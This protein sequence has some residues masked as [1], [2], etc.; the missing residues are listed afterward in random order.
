MDILVIMCIGV[1]IGN[2]WFPL[3]YKKWNENLQMICTLLLIFSMGT[4]LGRRENF[5]EEMSLIGWQSF[6]F[7]IVPTLLSI[8]VVY[9][10]TRYLMDNRRRRDAR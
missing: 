6:V 7:C 10:L 1:L 9:V 4:M 8:A 2:K 3:A 5:L